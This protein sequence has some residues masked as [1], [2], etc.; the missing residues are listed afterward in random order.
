MSLT[1]KDLKEHQ[2]ILDVP[3][4][5]KTPLLAQNHL[6]IQELS[7]E[8]G[9]SSTTIV[10]PG[11]YD[12]ITNSQGEVTNFGGDPDDEPII[13]SSDPVPKTTA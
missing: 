2:N 3:A 9:F 5:E 6:Q 4:V 13:P 10:Q 7:S 8:G 11:S 12:N 1:L